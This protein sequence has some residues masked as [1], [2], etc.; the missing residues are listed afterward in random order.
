MIELFLSRAMLVA[1]LETHLKVASQPERILA[2]QH[3]S[4]R[5]SYVGLSQDYTGRNTE[6][7]VT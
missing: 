4:T 1:M 7:R 3:K 2:G 6:K 5:E